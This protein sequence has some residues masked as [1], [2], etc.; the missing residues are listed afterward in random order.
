MKS[1]QDQ[2]ERIGQYLGEERRQ[3]LEETRGTDYA[4]AYAAGYETAYERGYEAGLRAG[5]TEALREVRRYAVQFAR[6]KVGAV[7]GAHADAI[8]SLNDVS[9]L[10]DLIVGIAGVSEP[11]ELDTLL[12][13]LTSVERP[14]RPRMM[15]YQYR[16]TFA[17]SY[18]AEG[19]GQEFRDVRQAAIEFARSKAPDVEGIL[20]ERIE[21][22]DTIPRLVELIA[23]L[24][25]AQT[26]DAVEAVLEALPRFA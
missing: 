5:R 9:A 4:A 22:I 24:G 20:F 13:R 18:I 16:S 6:E 19:R 2:R 1:D 8:G 10:S 11:A 21:Q 17:R 25:A 7:T 14:R 12:P 26:R 15:G 3:A 23:A